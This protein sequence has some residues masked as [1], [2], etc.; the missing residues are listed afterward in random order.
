MVVKLNYLTACSSGGM[1][2][3]GRDSLSRDESGS[4]SVI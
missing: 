4:H 1:G 3:A 2:S